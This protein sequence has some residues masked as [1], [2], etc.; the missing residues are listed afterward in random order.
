MKSSQMR[1]MMQAEELVRAKNEGRLPMNLDF[2]PFRPWVGV[3]QY[4]ARCQE[5]WD[6]TVV[7][8]VEGRSW[9]EWHYVKEGGGEHP[10]F[11][12][13]FVGNA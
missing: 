9:Q 11:R 5:Y 2:D 4:A 1:G 3:F 8:H 13:S 6:R 10:V 12:C 7:R